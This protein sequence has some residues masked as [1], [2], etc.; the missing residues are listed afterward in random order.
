MVG[1]IIGRV[2]NV[3]AL[4][5]QRVKGD[6]GKNNANN[7]NSNMNPNQ[8]VDQ[9]EQGNTTQQQ[10]QQQGQSKKKG[11]GGIKNIVEATLSGNQENRHKAVEDFMVRNTSMN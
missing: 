1:F 8:D 4:V 7:T 5:I 9:T 10:Q 2:R 3:I 11:R 6:D